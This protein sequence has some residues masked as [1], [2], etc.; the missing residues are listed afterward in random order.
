MPANI[1]AR[2]L[3]LGKKWYYIYTYL[4]YKIMLF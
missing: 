2:K 1:Y 4:W 3:S